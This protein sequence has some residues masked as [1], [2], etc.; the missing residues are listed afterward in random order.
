MPRK[1]NQVLDEIERRIAGNDQL[2][3]A[4]KAEIRKRA[5]EQVLETRKKA[6]TE[7]YLKAAIREEEREFE[8]DEQF[9]DFTV[10]LAEYAP[11]IMI[12][13]VMYFHGVTYEVPASLA[14]S[15]GEIQQNTWRHEREFRE[16]KSHIG[17]HPKLIQ[18]SPNNPNGV[19]T[20]T[21]NMRA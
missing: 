5:R 11:Y 16:G 15:L 10:N 14:R 21:A 6:A 17:M 20:T 4:D 1:K 18:I 8:P 19:V 3:D 9:E 12:N 2:T 13:G 7:A